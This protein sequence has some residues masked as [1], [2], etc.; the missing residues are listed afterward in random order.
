MKD[1]TPKR[2]S[3]TA[4]LQSSF[5][6]SLTHPPPR[7]SSLLSDGSIPAASSC[8]AA[9]WRDLARAMGT[10]GKMPKAKVLRFPP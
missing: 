1:Q 5:T 10:S 3:F 6:L 9:T 2:P 8:R 7:H 4:P